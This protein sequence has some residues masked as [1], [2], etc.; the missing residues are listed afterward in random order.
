[1]R[2]FYEVLT[3]FV[4]S[5]LWGAAGVAIGPGI[6]MLVIGLIVGGCGCLYSLGEKIFGYQLKL[7]WAGLI[8]FTASL[9][10]TL[11]VLPSLALTTPGY[12]FMALFLLIPS[13]LVIFIL[14][15]L[16]V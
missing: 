16:H 3:W 14:K 5:A 10:V 2:Y 15:K 4:A 7:A 6:I 12:I 11:L 8:I 9:T 1:V 13:Y